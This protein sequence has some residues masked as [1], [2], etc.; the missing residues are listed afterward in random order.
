MNFEK[1]DRNKVKRVPNRG[2][3][4][5][6]TIFEI[7]DA[8]FLCHAGF[9]VDDQPFVIPTLYGRIDDKIYLHGSAASRMLKNLA[10]GI[11]VCLTVTHV[12]GL[13]LARSAFHHSMNYR[14]AVIF[15]NALPTSGAEKDDALFAISEQVLKGR[16]EETREP[17]EKE[18]KATSVLR[19]EIESASAKIRTGPPGDEEE[20]YELP[21]WAGV[22]PIVQDYQLPVP[23]PKLTGDIDVS[24]SVANLLGKR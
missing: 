23:D 1:T 2:H 4:D 16:W 5:R 8:G 3:Y 9:V 12:D 15:G 11:P 14:S 22:V 17:N 24:P 18:L 20:D 19:V 6:G 10:D 21:I 7:L 13:V